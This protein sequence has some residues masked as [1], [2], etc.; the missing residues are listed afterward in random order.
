MEEKRVKM[1]KPRI[2]V[3]RC[4]GF[5]HCRYN[6]DVIRD[7]FVENLTP[8]VEYITVCPEVE[9]GLGI[10]RKPIRLIQEDGRLELY[11]PATDLL[12]T[13]DMNDYNERVLGS[14]EDIDGFIL[15]GR[16]PSCGIKDV[17]VYNGRGKVP[18]M[19]KDAGIFG[20]AVL[21]RFPHVPVEEEG[22]LTNLKIREHFLTKLY[23]M[24]RFKK[25]EREGTMKDLV[26]FHAD[27]KYLFM[28]YDQNQSRKLGNIVGNH[29]KLSF[30]EVV[31]KY[32]LVLSETLEEAP[33]HTNY[34]NSL[35]H[36]FGYFSQELSPE[37]REFILDSFDKFREDKVHLSVPVNLL[38]SYVLRFKDK[39]LVNQTIWEPFPDELLNISDSGK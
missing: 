24:K 16:S 19:G 33:K 10:P 23:T 20:G 12:F 30:K 35:M 36:I 4:L 1:D 38:R 7:D 2:V 9:I 37:E 25:V 27:N 26:K 13:G 15:K 11:Q 29:D 5:A 39:N 17:K 21:E 32:K 34:I 22:R 14:L 31:D 6:G 3:S 8:F 18:T 28:A